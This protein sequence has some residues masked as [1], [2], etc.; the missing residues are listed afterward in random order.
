VRRSE[1]EEIEG[2][3]S[4]EP[5]HVSREPHR[6]SNTLLSKFPVDLL[7]VERGFSAKPPL[8][9]EQD[10]WEKLVSRTEK[11]N[12]P[13]AIIET[14]PPNAQPWTK[15][16]TCKGTV[17]RWH[18]MDCASHCKRTDATNVGGAFDQSRLLIAPAKKEWSHLWA[19]SSEETEINTPR[20][21]SNSLTPPWSDWVSQ[22]C[23]W[24]KWR[25]NCCCSSHAISHGSLCPNGARN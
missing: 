9:H 2:E 12:Q 20:P 24:T 11:K 14:W 10:A 19:W 15:G 25:P 8:K 1:G 18:E 16:P 13:R 6:L 3:R 17:T 22:A 5:S 23:G 4:P 7:T 21:M